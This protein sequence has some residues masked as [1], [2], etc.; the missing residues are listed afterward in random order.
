MAIHGLYGLC[1]GDQSRMKVQEM[2]KER[3]GQVRLDA[4]G[5][6]LHLWPLRVERLQCPLVEL[7]EVVAGPPQP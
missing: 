5:W 1:P 6:L 3:E 4:L 7:E 2:G